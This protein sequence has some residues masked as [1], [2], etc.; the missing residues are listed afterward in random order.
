[1]KQKWCNKYRGWCKHVEE[2]HYDEE[3]EC[4]L[5]CVNC[6]HCEKVEY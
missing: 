1:M 6:K 4:D 5:D 3:I 2:Q